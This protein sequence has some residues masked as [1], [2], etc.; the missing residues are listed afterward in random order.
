MFVLVI[1]TQDGEQTRILCANENECFCK[2][3]DYVDVIGGDEWWVEPARPEE[4]V[5]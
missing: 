1:E 2:A 3:C 4:V 5:N